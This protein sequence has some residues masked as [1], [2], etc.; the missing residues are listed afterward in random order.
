MPRLTITLSEERHRALKES[1]ARRKK[2]IATIIEESLEMYGI[3]T[4]ESARDLVARA[5]RQSALDD[6]AALDLAIDETRKV[7]SK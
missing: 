7:R 5:R 1:A 3:K 2:S 4:T 6:R